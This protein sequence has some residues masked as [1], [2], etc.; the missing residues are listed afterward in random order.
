MEFVIARALAMNV[1]L[2]VDYKN[3]INVSWFYEINLPAVVS[4]KHCTMTMSII[5]ENV[6]IDTKE[7]PNW[8]RGLSASWPQFECYCKEHAPADVSVLDI[9]DQ[10]F[11]QVEHVEEELRKARLN[12]DTTGLNMARAALIEIIVFET[13]LNKNY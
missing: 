7:S 2:P 1:N 10:I 3:G 9:R 11:K 12:Q 6:R 13:W 8:I 4:C 5:S